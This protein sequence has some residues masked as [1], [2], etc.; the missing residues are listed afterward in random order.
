MKITTNYL[1]QVIK[2]ELQ[3]FLKEEEPA[4]QGEG[5]N[6]EED[7]STID[8]FKMSKEELANFVEKLSPEEIAELVEKLSPKKLAALVS[9]GKLSSANFAELEK[10][11][12]LEE[13]DKLKEKLVNFIKQEIPRLDGMLDLDIEMLRHLANDALKGGVYYLIRSLTQARA[14][15]IVLMQAERSEFYDENKKKTLDEFYEGWVEDDFDKYIKLL[16]R[17]TNQP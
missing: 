9:G 6:E 15:R 7:F 13:L 2:E 1:R 14:L 12:S 4:A 17:A 16:K 8:I 10:K 11:L 3:R 5:N